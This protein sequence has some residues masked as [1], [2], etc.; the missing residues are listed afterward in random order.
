[1]KTKNISL[2]QENQ[3][4]FDPLSGT[5]CKLFKSGIVEIKFVSN[6]CIEK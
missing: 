4:F 2:S 3:F 6:S 1:M 5:S